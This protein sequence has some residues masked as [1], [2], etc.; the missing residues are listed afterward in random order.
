M[1][2]RP[3]GS[4]NPQD[5]VPIVAFFLV[6]LVVDRVTGTLS[7]IAEVDLARW[8]LTMAAIQRRV[9]WW[10]VVVVAVAVVLGARSDSRRRLLGRWAELDHGAVLRLLAAPLIV[11]LA[12]KG[13]LYPYNVHAGQ[14]HLLDRFLLLALAA[15]ALWRPA[16]LIPFALQFRVIS[17]QTVFPFHTT[18]AR[19]I[20]DLPVVVLLLIG[21]GHLLFVLTG[22]RSTSLIVLAIGAALA[23]H[24]WIPGKGKL[25]MGWLS[26]DEPR[27]PAARR[28]HRRM[29]G[30]HRRGRRRLLSPRCSTG[31]AR[32][33]RWR[34]SCSNSDRS[35]RSPTDA[36]CGRG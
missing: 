31:S 17:A 14:L 36:S 18:A 23:S 9:V 5:I 1:L 6:Y 27:Q 7:E 25:L 4:V 34:P 20:D 15:A 2:R 24:F 10:A 13:A 33:S 19:N 35:S 11:F 29:V 12:W 16:L 22:R 28:L 21:V 32:S 30:S 3:I 26:A 8:S